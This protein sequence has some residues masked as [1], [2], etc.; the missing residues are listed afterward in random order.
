M[1]RPPKCCKLSMN[2]LNKVDDMYLKVLETQVYFV[3]F[4]KQ[5]ASLLVTL[6]VTPGGLCNIQ[7]ITIFSYCLCLVLIPGSL[8]LPGSQILK[9]SLG[10]KHLILLRLHESTPWWHV[11]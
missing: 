11:F 7:S 1:V 2:F 8:K 3:Y 9:I 5:R 10:L 6:P 4:V